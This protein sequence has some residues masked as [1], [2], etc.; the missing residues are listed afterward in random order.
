MSKFFD[1]F[2]KITYSFGDSTY[3]DYQVVTDIFLRFGI[4]K[5]ILNNITSYYEYIIT[6]GD[7][8]E[9]LAEKIYG[10]SEAHWIILYANDMVDPQ[11]DWPLNAKAFNNYVV[12]KYGSVANAQS[13]IHH[14]EK[15][16]VRTEPLTNTTIEC[17]YIVDYEPTSNTDVVSVPD[18]YDYYT[19]LPETQSVETHEIAGKTVTEIV[20]R[21]AIS[22]YDYESNL[23]EKKRNIKIIKPEYYPI[24]RENFRSIT[25]AEQDFIRSPK[26]KNFIRGFS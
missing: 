9:I 13:M 2:P 15:V 11:F 8:P 25:Q 21:D 12:D 5:N 16:V 22:V 23:N 19:N 7:K 6:D 1:T 18:T 20:S 4:L 24:I 26:R 3:K 17:R 14:Y 10:D